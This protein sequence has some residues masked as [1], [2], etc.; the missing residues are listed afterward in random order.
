MLSDKALKLLRLFITNNSMK[1]LALE[2][3]VSC[4]AM[5]QMS[6]IK[7]LFILSRTPSQISSSP[8]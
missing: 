6:M 5:P 4:S 1:I 3:K 8:R 2:T 7:K